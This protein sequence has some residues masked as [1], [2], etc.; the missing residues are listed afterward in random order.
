MKL[1]RL[2]LLIQGQVQ[3]VGFRPC[4]YRVAKR[5]H[6]SGWI[7]NNASGVLIE[8]QGALA[9][10]FVTHLTA[11]LPPL[12]KINNIQ[13]K[14][15]PLKINEARF[16]I[17]ASEKGKANTLISPDT[18]ICS[19][20]LQELFDPQS[21]YFRYPFLNCTH[22]GPRFS[23]TQTLPYDRCHTSMAAF[24]LC[25]SCQTDYINPDNR[26]YHAQPTACVHCGPQLS[27]SVAEMAQRILQGQLIAIKGLGGYQIICDAR[28]ENALLKLR[29]RKNRETKPL[30]LMVANIESAERTVEIN[31]QARILLESAA[32]P[33]VLLR[34]KEKSLPDEI[35]PGLNHLGIML[36]YTPLHYLLFNA[37]AGNPN[38][39]AW[40]NE[41][42]AMTLVVTSANSGGE[43]LVIDDHHAELELQTIADKIVSYNRQIITRE[44][45]SVLRI[46][47]E[48]PMFIRRSRGFVPTPIQLP[49][50]I[51]P[52]L[53]VGGHLKNT[54]C[55]TRGDEAFVSQHIG[56]LTNKATIDF[57]HESLN[58][59][60]NFLDVIPERIAHDLH[61]DFYTTRLAQHYGIPALAIQHHHAHLASVAAE[62][63]IQHR[64]LGLALDGYGYGLLGEARGGEF[65]LFENATFEPLG[66]FYPLLQPGGE[67]VAREPWRMAASILHC[68]GRGSEISK[69]F[70]SCPQAQAIV[71]LLDK[72]IN[73]PATTSCGRVFDAASA[74]LGIKLMSQYEGQ[75]AMR[76]ESLVTE[77]SVVPNG[78]QIKDNHFNLLP[79]LALLSDLGDPVAGANLFHGTLIAGL[80]AWINQMCREK[81]IDMILL[82]G[83]CFLNQ[84]LAEGLTKA[85]KELGIQP[86][87]PRALPP[88]DG[89]ISLGQAWITGT[90]ILQG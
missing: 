82:S 47:N 71:H 63:G 11:N 84:I 60:L 80:A 19:E 62:H 61:P 55:I 45:D 10:D 39:C 36:P 66:S 14:S 40:L 18:C 75:A 42:Q 70:S 50:A 41:Y 68:L 35:A 12:A 72:K 34:K 37:F 17:I 26:R 90:S 77:L 49:Y 53:A 46:I 32:R 86:L 54:F 51:P 44:D 22:C 48:A 76:L 25:P 33:I 16:E 67:I 83:G 28:N 1:E 58:H 52:T 2:Q 20:C 43:P 87:L 9:N 15:I 31:E 21:R 7:Q 38:G 69:R 59:L 3:G 13:L 89:G 30:A 85:L 4:V 79:T 64:I 24:P 65:F 78:W 88:N 6:L 81:G 5:L 8:V 57:F 29:E 73:S 56:S 27:L 74:L 23:I